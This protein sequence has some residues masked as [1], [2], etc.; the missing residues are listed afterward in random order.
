MLNFEFVQQCFCS[1][2]GS[3][4]VNHDDFEIVKFWTKV[5]IASHRGKAFYLLSF[6]KSL[7]VIMA[8]SEFQRN[9]HRNVL[10]FKSLRIWQKQFQEIGNTCKNKSP[11]QQGVSHRTLQECES[12]LYAVRRYRPFVPAV[13]SGYLSLPYILCWHINCN[14]N[15]KLVEN[16]ASIEP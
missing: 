6:A 8:H 12:L 4:S 16:R 11:G 1:V 10:T 13:N 2:V 5:E 9:Y 15:R 7:S 14:I 3:N